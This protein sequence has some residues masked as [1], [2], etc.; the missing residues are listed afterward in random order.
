[1]LHR[2][3]VSVS[4]R[5]RWRCEIDVKALLRTRSRVTVAISKSL[6]ACQCAARLH[7][8]PTICAGRLLLQRLAAHSEALPAVAVSSVALAPA[9]LSALRHTP[10]PSPPAT[11][12]ATLRWPPSTS[13][14]CARGAGASTAS[15]VTVT[16]TMTA[17]LHRHPAP[18]LPP[19]RHSRSR[20]AAQL[21][22]YLQ[23][24]LPPLPPS[25]G[26]FTS[27]FFSSLRAAASMRR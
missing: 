1:M 4:N 6:R 10:H 11:A 2:F 12:T 17:Q 24:P 27:T 3:D 7:V 20:S 26:L 19:Q 9:P 8:V 23:Q 13:H 16:V 18:A 25:T 22:A 15:A 5:L 21:Q 14:T